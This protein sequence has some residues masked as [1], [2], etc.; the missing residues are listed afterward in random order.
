LEFCIDP[1]TTSCRLSPPFFFTVFGAA[2]LIIGTFQGSFPIQFLG[3][4]TALI[5]AE[6]LGGMI[7]RK[8]AIAGLEQATALG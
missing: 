8:K 5:P 3:K 2:V 6:D 1:Q 4:L 7:R